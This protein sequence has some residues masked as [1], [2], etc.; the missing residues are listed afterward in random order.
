M[1]RKLWPL[2]LI[3]TSS[4]ITGC[5][6][7][8]PV[9]PEIDICMVSAPHPTPSD[10]VPFQGCICSK[11]DGVTTYFLSFQE[12]DKFVA[13]VPRQLD[14]FAEYVLKLEQMVNQG[15]KINGT[16]ATQTIRD[17]STRHRLLFRGR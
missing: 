10:P 5:K 11:P 7:T 13:F 6:G 15:C 3:L 12:C 9:R 14:A 17:F 4:F 16:I 8:I 1:L 2:L